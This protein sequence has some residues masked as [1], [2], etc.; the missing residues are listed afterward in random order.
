MRM[1]ASLLLAAVVLTAAE[2]SRPQGAG[3]YGVWIS[4]ERGASIDRLLPYLRGG[5]AVADWSEV[6]R[7]EG[8]YDFSRLDE[9]LAQQARQQR[10]CTIQINA[11][12]HPDYLY[13]RVPVLGKFVAGPVRANPR[14]QLQY[15]HPDY[16]A[17]YDR[18]LRAFAAHFKASPHRAWILGVRLNWNALS[19][20]HTDVPP[21]FRQPSVWLSPPGAKPHPVP[22]SQAV[23]DEY[24]GRILA[25][26][27]E[28][29]PPE[30]RIFSRNNA[31]ASEHL[32]PLL[33]PK[34]E[35]GKI[36]LFH[37]STEMEPRGAGGERQ[38]KTFLDY[39]RNGKS[40]CYAEPWADAEGHHGGKKDPRWCSPAQWNYW[41]LLANLHC[42]VSYVAVYGADLQRAADPEFKAAFDLVD[43]YAGYHASPSASPGA[44]VAF[45]EGDSMKGDYTFLMER[46]SGGAP[47]KNAGP[48]GQRYGA[49]ARKLGA[50]ESMVLRL[51]PLFAASLAGKTCEVRVI[52]LDEAGA[53]LL[54]E[55]GG[56][57]EK[58]PRGGT[59][60]WITHTLRS[61]REPGDIRI[62]AVDGGT[63]HWVEV[64]R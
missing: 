36:G 21:E 54:L 57:T 64:I 53:P 45:R 32:A 29:F 52:Y 56:R 43:R 44:W 40:V 31:L 62:S 24:Q 63:L 42:G 7:E 37:T 60:R 41:M 5:Q 30:I 19:T 34:V 22:Y 15:W 28:A 8:R 4:A 2:P 10:F 48:D 51:N 18:L 9:A 49:W 16:V 35:Q 6:E 17:A 38:Y 13:R 25:T 39:C 3:L 26:Y 11:S 46:V 58:L 50:K 55:A 59:G 33:V 47:V 27:L 14:G 61:P 12:G 1:I 20:E 23:R